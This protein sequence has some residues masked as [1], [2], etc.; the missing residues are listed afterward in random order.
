MRWVPLAAVIACGHA[1][2]VPL[3]PAPPPPDP[4]GLTVTLEWDAAVD[5]DLYVTD[6]AWVT[7]Y[8]A[9][10][11]GHLGAD[12]RCVPGGVS[13]CWERAHWTNPPNG[14]YRVGVDFPEACDTNLK[15]VPYRVIVDL[16]G[17]RREHT[18]TVR[19]GQRQPAAMEFSVP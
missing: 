17:L 15:A 7:V 13:A 8:Y 9:R 19:L 3:S 6:P 10:P 2:P 4:G 14:G 11:A 1:A 12:A 5:L 18:G 16:G